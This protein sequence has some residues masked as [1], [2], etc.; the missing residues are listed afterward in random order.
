MNHHRAGAGEPLLLLHGVGHRWGAWAPVL[1]DLERTFDVTACDSPGFGGSE[2]LPAG[3]P[4]TIPAYADAFGAFLAE[5]G[6]DRPHVAG[7]S[8][9]GAIALELARRGL[10]RSA[11]A[12]SP[13]G[14]WR[15]PGLRWC[16]GSLL[17]LDL[18]PRAARPGVRAL[19]RRPR[20]RQLL[21]A[22]LVKRG[23]DMTADA[24]I[25]D[26]DGLWAARSLRECLAGFAAYEFTPEPAIPSDIP[27]TI[28]WGD[29]D[30]LLTTRT[31][32]ARARQLLPRAE[33]VTLDGGHLP[34]ADDPAG[35]VAAIS[36]TAAGAA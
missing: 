32:A 13:A 11:T 36:A 7:N 1:P 9:G 12:V 28:A 29:A 20:G 10:V 15:A 2:P 31:Q 35:L 6:I 21:L 19:L 23:R 34:Y 5:Q 22:E 16:Q 30:H 17:A 25:A 8:M 18:L 33:H 27:V 3:V 14:F 24:A 4:R 26:V